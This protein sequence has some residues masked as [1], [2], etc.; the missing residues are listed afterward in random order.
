MEIPTTAYRTP[1]Q[2]R[3]RDTDYAR[4]VNNAVFVT[5]LEAARVEWIKDEAQGTPMQSIPLIIARIEVDYKL[6][7]ELS[8]HPEVA[9]WVSRIGTKSFDFE[10]VIMDTEEDKIYASAK[11][12]QVYYDYDT[13]TSQLIPEGIRGLLTKFS[14]NI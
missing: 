5:Y 9:M 3:W 7:I 1:V 13:N 14:K 4:H 12:V 8:A 10:Y 11:S 6:P 2:V